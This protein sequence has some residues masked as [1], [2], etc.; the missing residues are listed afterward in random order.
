MLEP[1]GQAIVTVKYRV[2]DAATVDGDTLTY[3]LDI[4]P[5]ATVN[6]ETVDVT[7]HLP[8][9]YSVAAPPAGWSATDAQ[10]LKLHTAM[11]D[12]PRFE[13]QASQQ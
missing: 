12:S 3:H 10:T 4:D 8:D 13:V 11:D 1:G 5:Q 9:G 2:P 7:L 6:P